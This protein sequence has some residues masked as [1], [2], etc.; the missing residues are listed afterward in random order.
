MKEI[1]HSGELKPMILTDERWS[2]F[3]ECKDFANAKD[4]SM[5][6]FQVHNSS[7]PSLKTFK[8]G[9]SP[10]IYPALIK[11]S[12]IVSGFKKD[13]KPGFP[14]FIGNYALISEV[15]KRFFPFS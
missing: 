15:Q 7:F 5:Y 6:S 1:A 10:L 12:L 2:T 3:N 13:D 14:S 4:S 11:A 8:A 9:L